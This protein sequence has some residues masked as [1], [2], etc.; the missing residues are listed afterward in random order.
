MTFA[1][2]FPT[3]KELR[4]AMTKFKTW[5][6]VV[7]GCLP[8]VGRIN[9]TMKYS[10]AERVIAMQAL[11]VGDVMLYS[12]SS[13][14]GWAIRIKSG[15]PISHVEVFVGDGQSVASRDGQG[16]GRY[17]VRTDHVAAVLRP[18]VPF[19]LAAAMV[20]FRQHEGEPYGFVDLL[21]FFSLNINGPGMVC[22]PCATEF[23]RAGG[24]RV[25]GGFP[26]AHVFPRD[27]LTSELLTAIYPVVTEQAA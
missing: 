18:H 1:E 12:P 3:D 5:Y 7:V 8:A 13:I 26:A 27:F 4:H 9:R 11:A 20:W 10:S 14:F 25:F 6:A 21:N 19:S 15:S 2:K 23:L 22:S 16:V 17:P 24:V